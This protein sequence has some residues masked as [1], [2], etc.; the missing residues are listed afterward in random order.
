[1]YVLYLVNQVFFSVVMKVV[2]NTVSRL[3]WSHVPF[4]KSLNLDGFLACNFSQ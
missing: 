1:M 2:Y 3:F 4:N